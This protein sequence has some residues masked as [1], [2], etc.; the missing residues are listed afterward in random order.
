[1]WSYD[2]AALGVEFDVVGILH[3]VT[4]D[5]ILCGMHTGGMNGRRY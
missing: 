3:I 2:T 5:M 1:M 4:V